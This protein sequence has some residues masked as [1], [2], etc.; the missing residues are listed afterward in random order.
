MA[1]T[2]PLSSSCASLD[3]FVFLYP[4]PLA[5]LKNSTEQLNKN[6]TFFSDKGRCLYQN[7]AK[8][9]PASLMQVRNWVFLVGEDFGSLWPLQQT[10]SIL[11]PLGGCGVIMRV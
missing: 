7:L 4:F 5:V 1:H 3:F 2:P 9:R 10:Q 8:E 6:K 11:T